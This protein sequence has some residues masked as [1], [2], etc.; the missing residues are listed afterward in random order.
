MIITP[1]RE[2]R[3]MV[4]AEW[5]KSAVIYPIYPRSFQ[6]SDGDGVGDLNGIRQRLPYLA[7]LGVD[8]VWVSPF[9]KS[10]MAEFG[11]DVADYCDVD[12]LFGTLADCQRLI[13][14]EGIQI[15]GGIGYTWEHDM[16]LF[17]KR[18]KSGEPLFGT[19]SW[20]R[21]RI[22]ALLGL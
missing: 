4:E 9:Y 11:Y 6:D 13:A 3:D 1:A 15:H 7:A 20:H 22:A 5:W 17:V 2:S 8:A 16:H 10:P 18:I 14:K 21:A 19:S 12:P